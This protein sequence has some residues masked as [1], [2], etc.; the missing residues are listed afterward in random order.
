MQVGSLGQPRSNR[1]MDSSKASFLSD[2]NSDAAV[3]RKRIAE[4]ELENKQLKTNNVGGGAASSTMGSSTGAD[5]DW[6][7]FG[8]SNK[9]PL[10]RPTT[11][12]GQNQ[13][14]RELENQLKQEQ[15]NQKKLI[16]E[17]EDLKKEIH[18]SNFSAFTSNTS[19][20]SVT[21]GR[22]PMVPGVREITE[23]DLDFGEQIG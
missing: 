20:V 23:A 5:R 15:R 13:K 11:A 22:L 18:K 8:S 16:N 12:T 2:S 9:G 10:E 7:N 4:L 21:A 3:L 1:V 19:E 17:I 14:V 6:L